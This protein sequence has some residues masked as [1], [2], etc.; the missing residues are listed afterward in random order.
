MYRLFNSNR[1]WRCQYAS[2]VVMVTSVLLAGCMD[3]ENSQISSGGSIQPSEVE[4]QNS[5]PVGGPELLHRPLAQAPQFENTGIWTADPIMTSG[6]S[7]YRNGE[8]LY[9]D[10]IYDDWG[11]TTDAVDTSALPDGIARAVVEGAATGANVGNYTY[12][13][14]PVYVG[15]A[16]DLL[17]L[18]VK[19]TEAGTA[20][21]ITYNSML[22]PKLAATTIVLGASEGEFEMPHGAN[23]KAPGKLFA[24][25]HG[26][27][28]EFVDA[29][30]GNTLN[31]SGSS[32]KVDVSRRQIEAVIPFSLFD[33]RGQTDVRM[34]AASGL[35]DGPN[36]RYLLPKAN[37]DDKNPGGAGNGS[38][39]VSAFFNVAFRY[40]ENGAWHEGNQANAL[41]SGDL[42]PFSAVIDFKKL[43]NRTNDDMPDQIGGTPKRGYMSRLYASHFE[44]QQ[45]RGPAHP[46]TEGCEE[47]C[48]VITPFPGNIQPYTLYVP[49]KAPTEAGYGL[50]FALH[51]CGGNYTPTNVALGTTPS[52]TNSLGEQ[53]QGALIVT[54]NGR[55]PCE[56]Y[57]ST[58]GAEIFEVWADLAHRF[59]L[60]P[61]YTTI[62]GGSMGGY[63]T[64]RTSGLWPDLF[65]KAAPY[66]PCASAETGWVGYGL[67]MAPNSGEAAVLSR[68]ASSY[69]NIPLR[70]AIGSVDNSCIS[71]A[72]REFR[73]AVDSQ[74]YRYEWREYPGEHVFGAVF[75]LLLDPEA[76][77]EF[78]KDA[79][80]DRNPARVSYTMN[81]RA[82]ELELGLNA[83]RA[84]WVS[85]IKLRDK[86]AEAPFGELDVYSAG[87]GL[88]DPLVFP[89]QPIAGPG[90]V[91]QAKTWGEPR[92]AT[93]ANKLNIKVKNIQNL[94]VDVQ[95]A[96]VGCDVL[97]NMETDGPVTVN[98]IG[99]NRSQSF[100]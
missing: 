84:Y 80:V 79:K 24:T 95:R 89:T 28:I 69:R 44:T 98:L 43:A 52:E 64:L 53:G 21:R 90:Y 8:F 26:D 47:P 72:Q 61:S 65:A 68:I 71:T 31:K 62:S 100:N 9:Q 87:L 77:P 27:G 14:N 78:F 25:I 66:I 19:L 16:A 22:D 6:A 3:N 70:I 30:T 7:A 37:A 74:G 76:V 2:V 35:W 63:G 50:S 12:P 54:T 56:W 42:S 4:V 94:D 29:A 92:A 58:A 88:M 1:H 34:A 82:N 10:Y 91:G 36:S 5:L 23:T 40:I 67:G 73:D 20:I 38:A 75:Y 99:C 96:K 59:K 86:S 39:P 48:N 33:P 60:D 51:A 81:Q 45:G 15:N 57:W 41:K 18:R 49:F 97:M 83:D 55:G 11:A 93:P 13:T 85:S 32:L 17:E 46:N